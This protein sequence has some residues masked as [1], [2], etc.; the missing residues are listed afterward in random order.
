MWSSIRVKKAA[1]VPRQAV[2]SWLYGVARQTTVRLRA[3]AAK[4]A[5]RETQ[6][7]NMP[8]PTVA[9][10]RDADL[11]SVLDEELGR[12]KALRE[13]IEAKR[14]KGYAAADLGP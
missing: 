5:R 1:D 2:A 14:K 4:R 11:Q 12:P 8:E 6:M 7:V 9:E 10:V 3:L 13:R